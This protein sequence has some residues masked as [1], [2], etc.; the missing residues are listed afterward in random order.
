MSSAAGRILNLARTYNKK[1]GKFLNN[2]SV[3][4]ISWR[5]EELFSQKQSKME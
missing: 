5:Q 2:F 4:F 3:T 1:K